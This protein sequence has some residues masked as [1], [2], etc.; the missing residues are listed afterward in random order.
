[1]PRFLTGDELGNIKSLN[2]LP[3]RAD[4]NVTVTTLCDGSNEGKERAV[5]KLAL[6]TSSDIPL[7]AVARSDGSASVSRLQPEGLEI[8]R[9]WIEPRLK[10]GQRYVGLAASSSAVYSCTSNGALRFTPLGEPDAEPRTAA[11]PMRLCEWRLAPERKTFAYGGDEVELSVWDLEA[12]FTTLS[13]H[14]EA[15]SKKRKRA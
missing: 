10:T 8:L 1:M 13:S 14:P 6:S 11:L 5:Q 7:L 3:S 15:S 9:E 2:Y 12:A 4:S